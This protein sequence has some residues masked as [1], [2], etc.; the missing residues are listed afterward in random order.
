MVQSETLQYFAAWAAVS[1][2]SSEMGVVVGV[3][4]FSVDAQRHPRTDEVCIL[5]VR[6]HARDAGR[7]A[8]RDLWRRN[9][10]KRVARP[11]GTTT[12]AAASASPLEDR[13]AKAIGFRFCCHTTV[14]RP[15]GIVP[16]LV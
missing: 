12:R 16:H 4:S 15:Q 13:V 14:V 8:K 6:T 2:R 7:S 9:G 3:I 1:S 5:C 10:G 11:S